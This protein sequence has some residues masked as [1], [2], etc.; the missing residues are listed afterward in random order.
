MVGRRAVR[1]R[2][3]CV[4]RVQT[5]CP[6]PDGAQRP[7][8]SRFLDPLHP[9]TSDLRPPPSDLY[10][11][12]HARAQV[13]IA[14]LVGDKGLNVTLSR[15]K[16][17]ALTRHLI[18]RLVAPMQEACDMAGIELDKSNMGTLMQGELK[19]AA[20]RVQQW[21]QQVAWRWRRLAQRTGQ[22]ET[23]SSD[24]R[25]PISHV[26]LVGGAT[27]MP[28]IGRFLKRLTGLQAKPTVQPD[29]AVALGAAAQV[30]ILDGRIKQRVFNPY[31]HDRAAS[32]LGQN[33][34]KGAAAELP[35]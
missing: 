22:L 25:I 23:R 16:F 17:E 18:L 9:P 35:A 4:V 34:A 15:R 13:E 5:A 33:V 6:L 2:L 10:L 32:K 7:H 21:Q 31:A 1:W 14:Y 30:G 8:P 24:A 11:S 3:P 20:P 28:A 27:R 12:C 29:E 19:R 26:L